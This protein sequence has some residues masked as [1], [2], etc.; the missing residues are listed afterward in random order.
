M[1]IFFFFFEESNGEE[2][3]TRERIF[4]SSSPMTLKFV[5]ILLEIFDSFFFYSSFI[6]RIFGLKDSININITI[7]P[8]LFHKCERQNFRTIHEKFN[9]KIKER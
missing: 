4:F 8:F 2:N 5:N 9:I 1:L 6:H 3:N 7:F